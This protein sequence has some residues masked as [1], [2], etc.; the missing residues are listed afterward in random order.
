MVESRS[1]NEPLCIVLCFQALALIVGI[2]A[3]LGGLAFA[4]FVLLQGY[5]S[6]YGSSDGYGYSSGK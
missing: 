5:K 2:T 3:L 1:V 6:G 4:I